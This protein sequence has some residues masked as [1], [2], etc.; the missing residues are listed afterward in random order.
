MDKTSSQMSG[1]SY[2]GLTLDRKKMEQERLARLKKRA[3]PDDDND[4]D[5]AQER[6]RQKPKMS[7]A[8]TAAAAV[9]T[10]AAV[11]SAQG[12]RRVDDS[13]SKQKSP[14]QTAAAPAAGPPYQYQAGTVR[15]TWARGYPRQAD[16]IAIDE[17]LQKDKLELA[18]IS[19]FQ[20]DDEWMLSKI[21]IGRTRLLLVSFADGDA[22][23][24][25][26]ALSDLLAF[27]WT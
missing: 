6:P 26:V 14:S 5:D 8:T 20:W 13:N 27:S 4:D 23:V 21:D 19:S 16:D 15:R 3:A 25:R 2:G 22:M 10:A 17:I 11:H 9:D 7:Q 24:R 1:I 18:V 12:G